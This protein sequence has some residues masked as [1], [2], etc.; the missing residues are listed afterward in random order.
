LDHGG[1]K[2]GVFG[3]HRDVLSEASNIQSK[4][5]RHGQNREF[6]SIESPQKNCKM[7]GKAKI[8]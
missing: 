5:Y 3:I 8:D 4:A 6:W 1:I 2:S 7:P